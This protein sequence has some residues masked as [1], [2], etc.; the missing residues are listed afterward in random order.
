[1]CNQLIDGAVPQALV[2]ARECRYADLEFG[3]KRYTQMISHYVPPRLVA[4]RPP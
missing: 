4:A 1:M 3:A 2:Y